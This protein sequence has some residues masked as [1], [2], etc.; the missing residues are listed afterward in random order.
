MAEYF[1]R[2]LAYPFKR[3]EGV[4]PALELLAFGV[5]L[6]LVLCACM[7]LE[8]ARPAVLGLVLR[9]KSPVA[10]R[11]ADFDRHFRHCVSSKRSSYK[12]LRRG[13]SSSSLIAM[14]E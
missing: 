8:V 13:T 3:T 11:C 1:D 12:L 14:G 7:K 10:G 9:R 6:A 2:C 4:V 5:I